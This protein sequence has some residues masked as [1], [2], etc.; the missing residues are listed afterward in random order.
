M[1]VRR[2][3]SRS[4]RRRARGADARGRG[5]V[6]TGDPLGAGDRAAVLGRR[7]DGPRLHPAGRTCACPRRP[8]R[9]AAAGPPSRRSAPL[10]GRGRRHPRRSR[11]RDDVGRIRLADH[12]RLDGAVSAAD[13]ERARRHGSRAGGPARGIGGARPHTLRRF[14]A[15]VDDV[16]AGGQHPGCVDRRPSLRA[17]SRRARA[18]G[19][20]VRAARQRPQAARRLD[21]DDRHHSGSGADRRAAV[22]DGGPAP[23]RFPGDRARRRPQ[24]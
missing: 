5:Q 13:R 10:S 9:A 6:Q 15:G 7:P 12:H 20:R 14:P 2:L 21:G 3:G 11:G 16:A 19:A 18:S 8:C 23:S 4:L 22:V 1:A 24:E 17:R